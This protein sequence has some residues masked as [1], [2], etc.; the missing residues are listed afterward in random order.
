MCLTFP[1]CLIYNDNHN[2]VWTLEGAAVKVWDTLSKRFGFQNVTPA[3]LQVRAKQ[4]WSFPRIFLSEWSFGRRA[5][6]L[7]VFEICCLA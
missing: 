7:C 3:L 4:A 5:S 2:P 1:F 6:N